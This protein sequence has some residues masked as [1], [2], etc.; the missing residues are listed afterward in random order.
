MQERARRQRYQKVRPIPK[1]RRMDVRRDEFNLVID[2]LNQRGEILN[3][4]LHNQE[5][6][7][8]RI[9]QIQADLDVLKRTRAKRALP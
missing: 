2:I 3:A 1:G 5:I 8:Q 4:I 6:Q 7:F 9:A